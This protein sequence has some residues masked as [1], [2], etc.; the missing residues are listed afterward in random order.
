VSEF[1]I[2]RNGEDSTRSSTTD[3]HGFLPIVP[4]QCLSDRGHPPALPID[5]IFL[6]REMSVPLIGVALTA[7][8]IPLWM[9]LSLMEE[10]G[11]RVERALPAIATGAGRDARRE[12]QLHSAL[13]VS[14]MYTIGA[15]AEIGEVGR[16]ALEIANS[17]GD[18]EYQLRSLWGLWSFH[19]TSGEQR[20]ALALAQ[21]FHALAATRSAPR[22]ECAAG[23][24]CDRPRPLARPQHQPWRRGLPACDR[25]QGAAS[26][27]NHAYLPSTPCRADNARTCTGAV[28][29]S[30]FTG[31]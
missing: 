23:T 4:K 1:L 10:C 13:A 30:V 3:S 31:R 7:A 26:A 15:V 19:M 2:S 9:Q 6:K 5:K 8:A 16:K 14:L 24:L 25:P 28:K 29:R 12:M 18:A 20:V 22:P 27:V 21:R 11:R 17:L